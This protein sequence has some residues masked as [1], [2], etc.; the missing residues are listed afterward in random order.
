MRL[1]ALIL[2]P[3]L[4]QADLQAPVAG[5]IC[6]RHGNLRRI[7]GVPG[8]F[9]AGES[10]ASGI[11]SASF[12][13]VTGLAKA[14]DELLEFTAQGVQRRHA[15]PSGPAEFTFDERGLPASARFLEGAEVW[16]WVA[17]RIEVASEKTESSNI[18]ER[19]SVHWNVVHTA[20]ADFAVRGEESLQLPEA[21]P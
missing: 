7:L 5:V 19:M 3:L 21:L 10:L 13:G 11:L 17:G 16:R 15:A 8:A 6:D 20:E 12:S 1:A 9:V 14:E 4:L 2:L 18:P